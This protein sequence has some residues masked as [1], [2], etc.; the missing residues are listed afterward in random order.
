MPAR[1]RAGDVLMAKIDLIDPRV[2]LLLIGCELR[3]AEGF[4]EA[5]VRIPDPS[6]LFRY[7]LEPLFD[8]EFG[9]DAVQR[10]VHLAVCRHF[11]LVVAPDTSGVEVLFDFVVS[12][13]WKEWAEAQGP[14]LS[15]KEAIEAYARPSVAL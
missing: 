7:F 9:F 6:V 12:P 14:I 11:G 2:N 13:R 1:R 5:Y 10:K 15:T 8:E 4:R 3:R